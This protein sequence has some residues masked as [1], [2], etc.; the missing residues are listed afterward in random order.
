MNFEVHGIQ[1]GTGTL[2]GQGIGWWDLNNGAVTGIRFLFDT[3]DIV[4]GEFHLFGV[5]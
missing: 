2:H 1:D 5:A 4:R 3:G